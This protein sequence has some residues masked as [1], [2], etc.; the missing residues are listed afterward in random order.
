[1]PGKTNVEDGEAAEGAG[2]GDAAQ[3]DDH[4]VTVGQYFTPIEAHG[5]RMSLEQAGLSAWV[6]DESLGAIY[7]VGI[8]TRLQVRAQDEAAAHAILSMEPVP[9]SSDSWSDR[10]DDVVDPPTAGASPPREQVAPAPDVPSVENEGARRRFEAIELVAVVLL[11]CASPIFWNVLRDRDRLPRGP[12]ELLADIPWYVGLTLVISILLRRRPAAL[13]PSPLPRT[14]SSWAREIFAG[15]M[16]FLGAWILDPVIAELLR[17]MGVLD[18]PGLDARWG[19]FF[20]QTGLA[21]VYRFESFFAAAYEETV[22]RAYLIAR[23]SLFLGRPAWAVLLAAA[24]FALS[25]GYPPNSTL[26][27]FVFGVV[28]GLV[29]LSSRSLPRLVLAHWIYN[30]AVMSH[31]LHR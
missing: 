7:G 5:H 16:L 13:S 22:F 29:Y 1:L 31:Y 17:Q 24:L 6:G 9:A 12:G 20:R 26:T 2:L 19:S 28:F 21:G 15:G 18:D 4:L 14:W 10:P 27:I 25:H 3:E 8:G 11:T 23:L 30:L